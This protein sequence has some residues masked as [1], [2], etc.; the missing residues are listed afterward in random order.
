M[1]TEC[2]PGYLIFESHVSR[3]SVCDVPANTKRNK[4][5]TITSK[6]RLCVCWVT[7]MMTWKR[8]WHYCPSV[9][10]I[11][12][13]QADSSYKGPEM[14]SLFIVNAFVLKN[15]LLRAPQ[16]EMNSYLQLYS[17]HE[18]SV[19]KCGNLSCYNTYRWWLW[20]NWHRWPWPEHTYP[21]ETCKYYPI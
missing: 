4:H 17:T 18:M 9:K 14:R 5:V 12:Q 6:R 19:I 1:C 2:H 13:W 10:G 20:W 21:L 11:H 15:S 16:R 3:C 8:F 7:D